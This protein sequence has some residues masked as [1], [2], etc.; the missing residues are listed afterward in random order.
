VNDARGRARSPL[1][2]VPFGSCFGNPI[3]LH[4]TTARQVRL[5]YNQTARRSLREPVSSRR[6]FRLVAIT[7]AERKIES[8]AV[9][10]ETS[11]RFLRRTERHAAARTGVTRPTN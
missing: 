10:R 2:A 6:R 4:S 9:S 1:R 5:P 7:G 11:A 8:S 3:R